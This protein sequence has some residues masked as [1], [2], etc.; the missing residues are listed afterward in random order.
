M[1]KYD[2][3]SR[4]QKRKAK[5][6]K[7]AAKSRK[8]EPLAYHGKKY[9]TAEY[10]GI[11]LST[12]TGIYESYVLSDRKLTD[13]EVEADLE[14]LILQMRQGPLPPLGASEPDGPAAE[15]SESLIAWN[16]RRHWQTL[17][18]R[19]ALPKREDMIGVLRTILG[20]L[21]T[22]RSKSMHSQGYL[23][24]LEGFMKETGVSVVK[25]GPE[26]ELILGPDEDDPLLELG[27]DWIEGDE[28]AGKEF[29]EEM[30]ALLRSGEAERV[31]DVCQE[32]LGSLRNMAVIPRLQAFAL[33]AHQALGNQIEHA[34]KRRDDML[35]GPDR[36]QTH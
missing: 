32:L 11:I 24:F 35:P 17:E 22:W 8:H 4:D 31:I 16:I 9:K 3:R 25:V 2:H 18:E 36:P 30:E 21:E 12:E 34:P 14:R 19:Q 28:E 23:R 10:V 5:L 20:S 26:D 7:E 29:T 6:K 13:D 1:G 15:G 33:R 27:E